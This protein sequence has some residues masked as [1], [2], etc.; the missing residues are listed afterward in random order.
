MPFTKLE[1]T[2][3]IKWLSGSAA[4]LL[5]ISCYGS[6]TADELPAFPG[7]EGFGAVAIGGRG[8]EVIKVTN[9]NPSGPGSLQEAC[10]TPGPRIVVFEVGG[11]IHG[12]V[13]IKH[14]YI[15]I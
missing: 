1:V 12:D 14:S 10:A 11:V 4:F 8:G 3:M 9:L 2:T 15:T 6:L 5:I 7:A 13:A